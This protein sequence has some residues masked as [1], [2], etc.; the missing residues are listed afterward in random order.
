MSLQSGKNQYFFFTSE[1][2]V[3]CI[4]HQPLSPPT[5]KQASKP[6]TLGWTINRHHST[7]TVRRRKIEA[8]KRSWRRWIEALLPYFSIISFNPTALFLVDHCSLGL[9]SHMQLS[10]CILFVR[11]LAVK[12]GGCEAT[13]RTQ[14]HI[15][16]NLL[17][18]LHPTPVILFLVD[19]HDVRRIRYWLA[20]SLLPTLTSP[21]LLRW[22]QYRTML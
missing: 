6:A 22:G 15:V 18:H 21:C 8:K 3:P 14:V 13:L 10:R 7:S 5:T 2:S 19:M 11:A 1:F 17:Q 4:L 9:S 12:G 16:W 20:R